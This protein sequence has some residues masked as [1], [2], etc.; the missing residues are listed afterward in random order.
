M[1]L[2]ET[3]DVVLEGFRP[4]VAERLGVDYETLHRINPGLV[5]CSITGYGQDGPNRD[6]AG[7]DLNYLAATGMLGHD[8]A[9]RWASD[10]AGRADR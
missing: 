10:P 3:A 2:V 8:R 4:G 7:H 5:Y 1:R 9:G 6:R